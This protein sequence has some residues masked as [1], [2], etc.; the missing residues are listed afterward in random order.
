LG[1]LE[2]SPFVRART[3]STRCLHS[4]LPGC[5]WP[6]R[7]ISHRLRRSTSVMALLPCC[8]GWCVR[9]S[10]A[11]S[12]ACEQ[13]TQPFPPSGDALHARACRQGGLASILA[14]R[15]RMQEY[16]CFSRMCSHERSPHLIH[17]ALVPLP[18]LGI[19]LVLLAAQQRW[20]PHEG[21]GLRAKQAC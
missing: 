14:K 18:C 16:A 3:G 10:L 17:T 8:D 2:H 1:T 20:H 11:L 6:S 13:W 12:R 7:P 5:G 4:S 19:A 21:S 15:P 9:P